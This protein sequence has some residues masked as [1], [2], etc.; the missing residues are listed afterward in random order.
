M[1]DSATSFAKWSLVVHRVTQT[2]VEVWVGTLF[3]TMKK[4]QQARIVLTDANGNAVKT[5]AFSHSDWLRPFRKH[6]QRFYFLHTFKSLEAGQFYRLEFQRKN[7]QKWETLRKGSF[8]TLPDQLPVSG[9]KPF[10]LGL[11]SCFYNH[12]DGGQA[13]ASYKALYERGHKPDLTF[14]V[15]DQVYLDIGFDSLSLWPSEIRQRIADD[16]ADHWQDLGSILSRGGT[17]MLPDD[18][19]YW[20]DY[21]FHDSLIPTLLAL[22]LPYVRSNWTRASKDAVN[23]IQRSPLIDTFE[24]GNDIS[25]CLADVRSR[26]SKNQFLP[27]KEFQQLIDWATNLQTPGVLVMPQPLIVGPNPTERNLLSFKSNYEKLIEALASSGHD[28]V[29]LSG[30]VHYGRIA[31]VSLGAAGG[32]L[33]EII[34][35]PL[36]NLTGLN[37]IATSTAK[38]KPKLFPDASMSVPNLPQQTVNYDKDYFVSTRKGRTLSAY[39]KDRTTEHF[40]TIAFSKTNNGGVKLQADAWRVRQRA[41]QSNLP[42]KDFDKSFKV[43]LK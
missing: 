33:I 39:P 35:S 11:G 27:K 38:A 12:R 41:K 18:H 30:D 16:Y 26:R 25:F 23:N 3:P 20:N 34:S 17:W 28:I 15:G 14:L 37:G 21:P 36:S 2:S 9:E 19:E 6:N 31:S 1:S 10:T 13:A 43:T 7:G 5:K 8:D 24:I 42:V 4:P 29:V 32:R 40:M 22:K